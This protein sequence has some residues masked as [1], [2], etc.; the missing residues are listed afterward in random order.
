[1]DFI[2][3]GRK[4]KNPN[5]YYYKI[6]KNGRKIYYEA[7]KDR[8]ISKKDIASDILDYIKIYNG[9]NDILLQKQKLD[10]L[11]IKK[12]KLTKKLESMTDDIEKLTIT[13]RD[14]PNEEYEKIK[15]NKKK[16]DE[17]YQEEVKKAYGNFKNF[18]D[19]NYKSYTG[20]SQ[21]SFSN[22]EQILKNVQDILK[23]YDIV[24]KKDW[25]LWLIKNHPDKGGD[26]ETCKIVI[27]NG[28]K[29]GW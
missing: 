10:N 16:L 14:V 22:S 13:L 19:Q 2:F 18:F 7:R 29:M 26:E 5:Q 20:F 6:S 3:N 17:E 27:N 8:I 9:G 11:K 28:R 12:D 21:Q 15:K 24:T 1:M 23:K 25:K 4:S